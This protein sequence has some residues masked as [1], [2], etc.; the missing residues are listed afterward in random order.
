MISNRCHYALRAMLELA[1]RE[2]RG[3]VTIAE[4]AATQKIPVRFLEA[5]MRQLKQAGLADS[6]RGKEG[7]YFLARPAAKVHV[8]DV[9]ALFEG[10]L[11]TDGEQRGPHMIREPDADAFNA[12][13]RE[14]EEALS[15]VFSRS[16]FA[17]LVEREQQRRFATASN[18]TI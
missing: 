12:I 9:L 14:A 13:W 8:G 1:L 4:I 5:I 18:Y 6:V 2:G 11:F 16:T 15:D 3:P 17:S 7:G 10:P